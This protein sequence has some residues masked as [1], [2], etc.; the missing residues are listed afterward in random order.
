MLLSKKTKET[1]ILC[2]G[3]NKN[4]DFMIQ[5]VSVVWPVMFKD[6]DADIIESNDSITMCVEERCC[7][8]AKGLGK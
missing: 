3:K 6:L 7:R 8:D 2:K 4:I 1:G 5:I